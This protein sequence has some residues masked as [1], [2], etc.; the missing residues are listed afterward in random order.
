MHK[1]LICINCPKGCI[2]DV[3]YDTN[4]IIDIQGNSCPQGA[5]Y[6]ESEIFHPTR[7]LTSTVRINNGIHNMLSVQTDKPIPKDMI[8]PIMKELKKVKVDA[9]IHINDIIIENVLNT[10]VNIIATRSMEFK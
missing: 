9:P 3:N 8:F 6:V 4:K 2:I 1:Q 10:G 7:M 5:K